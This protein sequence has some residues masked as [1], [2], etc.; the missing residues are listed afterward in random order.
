MVST[1]YLIVAGQ[2][3]RASP[4]S[5]GSGTDAAANGPGKRFH[6]RS[7]ARIAGPERQ[8]HIRTDRG[9]P[10]LRPYAEWWVLFGGAT[11]ALIAADK[12]IDR[13]LPNS[14]TEMSVGNWASRVGSAYSLIPLSAVF[15]FSGAAGHDER[16]PET[17]LLA[18][19]EKAGL[20]RHVR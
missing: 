9:S 20:Q 14:S 12:S 10:S 1:K 6:D 16:L 5:F 19:A 11:G 8:G 7:D 15:Y 3:L 2:V 4:A 13:K 18:F 17:G